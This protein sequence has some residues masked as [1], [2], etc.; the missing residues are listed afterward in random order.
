MADLPIVDSQVRFWDGG[1]NPL[2]WTRTYPALDRPFLPADLAADLAADGAAEEAAVELQAMVVVEAE[3]D[4]GLYLKE[5][6]WLAQLAAGEPPIGAIVAHAPL[7]F[8]GAVGSELEKL[9]ATPL[10]RGV[11]R[12]LRGEDARAL[13]ADGFRDAVRMLPRHGLHCELGP[14]HD[15]LATVGDLVAACPEVDFV[16]DHLATPGAGAAIGEPWT[17]EIRRLA[18]FAN[19]VC[20]IAA[21]A[22]DAT[23]AA[24]DAARLQPWIRHALEAFGPDRVLFASDWPVIR[25]AGTYRGWLEIVTAAVADWPEADRA[26]LFAENARRVY[27]L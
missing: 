10:V 18:G 27:R 6:S 21:S 25:L 22:G 1:V 13:L 3:V 19:V 9:A 5:A 4:E 11:R 16:L 7:H 26:K 14:A 8:G 2:A 17:A 15:Q 12:R 20:K 23:P 24:W